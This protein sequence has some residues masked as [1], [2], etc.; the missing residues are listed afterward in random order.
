VTPSLVPSLHRARRAVRLLAV[1]L[2]VV[3]VSLLS[4]PTSAPAATG[5]AS[6]AQLASAKKSVDDSGV[7]GIAWYVDS[8]THHVVVTADSTVT[9][10][11]IA[12]VTQAAGANADTLRIVRT[13]GVF[14]PLLAAGDG[15]T[16]AATA[17]RSAST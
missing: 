15:S 9:D 7:P 16:A 5:H 2:A 14:R 12:R 17:A 10:R 4:L 11:E 3:A 1:A 13:T 6:K 8:T